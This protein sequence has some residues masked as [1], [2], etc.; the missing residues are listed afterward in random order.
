[1]FGGSHEDFLNQPRSVT[2]WLIA[3]DNTMN[4]VERG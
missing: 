3:I 4:E 1:M 2:D